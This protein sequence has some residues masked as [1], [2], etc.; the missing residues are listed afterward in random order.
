MRF[1]ILGPSLTYSIACSS[2]AMAIGE[3]FRAIR[4]GYLDCVLAGGAESMVNDGTIVAWEALGV[5]AKEHPDGPAASS[6]PFAKDR[7]GFVLGEGAATLV[8]EAAEAVEARGGQPIAEIV[9]FDRY[10]VY[11]FDYGVPVAKTPDF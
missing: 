5:L 4:D 9:G 3:A 2:S 1:G 8:L 11:L 6:R 10:A 7:T